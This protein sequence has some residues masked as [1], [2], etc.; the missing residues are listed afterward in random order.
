MENRNTRIYS[1][2]GGVLCLLAALFTLLTLENRMAR[3][4]E[5]YFLIPSIFRIGIYAILSIV[6]LVDRHDNV[7]KVCFAFAAVLEAVIFLYGF[8]NGS[9]EYVTYWSNKSHIY[10]SP[11]FM[12]PPFSRIA[13]LLFLV[14]TASLKFSYNSAF[15]KTA[16]SRLFL[17]PALFAIGTTMLALYGQYLVESW[18]DYWPASIAYLHQL[19]IADAILMTICYLFAGLWISSCNVAPKP[20]KEKEL[21][22]EIYCNGFLF[23]L[24]I[25]VTCGIWLYVWI[26]RVTRY[27]NKIPGEEERNPTTKLLLCLFVPFYYLY[28]L[29]QSAKRID[30][31][32]SLKG[33]PSDITPVCLILGFFLGIIPPFVMQS[34]LNKISKAPAAVDVFIPGGK[35]NFCTFCGAKTK[36]GAAFCNKCGNRL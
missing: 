7:P 24:L 15:C 5:E 8:T 9:Y 33:I 20:R 23:F 13:A 4:M 31:L 1:I 22:D 28:W 16:A 21:R 17:F 11:V 29:Y 12:L 6:L 10:T 25:F 2:A 35:V 34:K 14:L 32:A 27:L 30:K 26:Y 3:G 18:D 36:P 19:G